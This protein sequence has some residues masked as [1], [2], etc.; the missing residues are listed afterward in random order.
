MPLETVTAR[1]PTER[2]DAADA[3]VSNGGEATIPARAKLLPGPPLH[4]VLNAGGATHLGI[5][6]A[7]A[8][9]I[10][11]GDLVAVPDRNGQP[12]M[13]FEVLEHVGLW[14]EAFPLSEGMEDQFA[15]WVHLTATPARDK[16]SLSN[17]AAEKGARVAEMNRVHENARVQ[18]QIR[19]AA[20]ECGE[21]V[22]KLKSVGPEHAARA[23]DDVL[24]DDER[25]ALLDA[26][27][28]EREAAEQEAPVAAGRERDSW[29]PRR[30][31]RAPTR[32]RRRRRR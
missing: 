19:R 26:L 2:V 28:V 29:L 17:W 9:E 5:P 24:D 8:E 1:I 12:A 25:R 3:V 15:G 6:P 14:A 10:E 27:R 22:E 18:G 11:P 30:A 4:H 7:A 32:T 23:V 20:A 16:V 31:P 21:I 13:V